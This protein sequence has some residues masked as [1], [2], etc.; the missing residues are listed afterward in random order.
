[1]ELGLLLLFLHERLDF[2]SVLLIEVP[3]SE[4]GEC[5]SHCV[6]YDEGWWVLEVVVVVVVVLVVWRRL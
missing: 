5:V 6:C 1:L 2:F 3:Q 4:V